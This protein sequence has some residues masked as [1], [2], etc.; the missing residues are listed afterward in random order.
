MACGSPG[1]RLLG[2][3]YPFKAIDR[4]TSF[5]EKADATRPRVDLVHAYDRRTGNA[6]SM[7]ARLHRQEIA[8]RRRHRARHRRRRRVT[9]AQIASEEVRLQSDLRM[10][11][12]R[13]R[14]ITT[15]LRDSL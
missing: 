8:E 13:L 7:S 14:A 2:M 9:A 3:T 10:G 12:P 15:R 11:I 6:P 5:V 4:R 1:P